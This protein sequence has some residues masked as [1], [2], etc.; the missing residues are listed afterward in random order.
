MEKRRELS[1]TRA[2]GSGNWV[3]SFTTG[4]NISGG[5]DLMEMRFVWNMWS[6][7][8]RWNIEMEMS[9]DSLSHGPELK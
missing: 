4:V 1:M 2:V 3:M 7:G 8:Y 9:E 5:A 6:L